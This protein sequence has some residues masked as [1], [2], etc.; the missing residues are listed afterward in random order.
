MT[1][2]LNRN[3]SLI[4]VVASVAILA[5]LIAPLCGRKRRAQVGRRAGKR[6]VGPDGD[7][8]AHTSGRSSTPWTDGAG[9]SPVSRS[10]TNRHGARPLDAPLFLSA[11]TYPS[12]GGSPYSV[13]VADVNGDG[14]PDLLVANFCDND[15]STGSVG[16][17][18]GNGDGTFQPPVTTARVV[19]GHFGS[20]CRRERRRQARLGGNELVCQQ[21][22]RTDVGE[23]T[24]VC[25]WAMAT[26]PSSQLCPTTRL[27]SS[28][29]PSR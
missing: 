4:V 1:R 6:R 20:G 13:A 12:G 5:L 29:F 10:H 17:L 23:E 14:K 18:L 16:V 24:V 28:P 22:L 11:V 2:K 21:L 27:G 3:Y 19:R 26:A 15:C 9:R 8:C 7:L 25:C